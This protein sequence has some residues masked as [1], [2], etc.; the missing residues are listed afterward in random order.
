MY[1]NRRRLN[2]GPFAWPFG[3]LR[4]LLVVGLCA[5]CEFE[6]AKRC[7]HERVPDDRRAKEQ[8]L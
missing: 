4:R 2:S 6:G 8:L 1:Q 3:D 7:T 5:K